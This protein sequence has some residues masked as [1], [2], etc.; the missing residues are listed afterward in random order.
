MSTIYNAVEEDVFRSVLMLKY[1]KLKY[2]VTENCYN[3]VKFKNLKAVLKYHCYN[4]MIYMLLLPHREFLALV[5]SEKARSTNMNCQVI[6]TVKH[7]NSEPVVDVT[8][9]KYCLFGS[10]SSPYS[11]TIKKLHIQG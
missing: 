7:D 8:Y 5:A 10:F 3:Q 1:F 11:Y 2:K 6:T 9:C 4:V